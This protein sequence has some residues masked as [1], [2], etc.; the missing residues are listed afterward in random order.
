LAGALC[1]LAVRC[2]KAPGPLGGVAI[3]FTV[4]NQTV[5]FGK[6]LQGTV[7]SRSLVLTSAGSVDLTVDVVP[8]GPPF[9]S[10][11]NI[12]V[13]R[14][15]VA[16]L[17]LWFDAGT[18]V[19]DGTVTLSAHGKSVSVPLHG[20]GVQPLV[21]TAP[22][23]RVST[24]DLQ[25]ESCVVTVAADGT[26]CVPTSLCLDNGVCTAGVCTGSPRNCDDHDAC[27]TDTCA[28]S[29]G[30]VHSLVV[31]P[32]PTAACQV[33]T[34]SVTGGCGTAS[35]ADGTP[36]GS[37]DCTTA[38]VCVLGSCRGLPTPDGTPCLPPTP[39]QGQATCQSHVCVRPD[40]GDLTPV[41]SL[42]LDSAPGP[43]PDE[44]SG[45]LA[46]AGNLFWIACDAGCTLESFTSNGFNRFAQPL[47]DAGPRWL[48]GV[49]SA[50]VV[51]ASAQG[52]EVYDSQNGLLLWQFDGGALAAPL[53]APWAWPQT[54]PARAAVQADG[55]LFATFSWW[56]SGDAGMS[57]AGLPDAGLLPDVQSLA[58][59]GPDGG[60]QLAFLL[61][62]SGAQSRLALDASGHL[63][64]YDPDGPL[65]SVNSSDAGWVVVSLGSWPGAPSLATAAGRLL[66]G[67]A[68][69]LAVDGGLV[70]TLDAGSLAAPDSQFVLAADGQ[71]VGIYNA[72]L[73]PLLPPCTP[74][75]Q[76]VVLRVAD[77]GT[78]LDLWNVGLFPPGAPVQVREVALA[79]AG[80]VFTASDVQPDGGLETWVQLF[81]QGQ[82]VFRCRVP[83]PSNV[84]SALFDNGFFYLLNQRDGG[85]FL[86][87][88][89]LQGD[90]MDAYAWP[91]RNGVSGTR[92]EF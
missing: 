91:Q 31:C 46:F 43:V 83:P 24:F 26:S 1:L 13:P 5:D 38:H 75:Q 16:D 77:L 47:T 19:V 72:C 53:E 56:G 27:T 64:A 49:T 9:S 29:V 84:A 48:A 59:V 40:A 15:G 90:P 10:P 70:A 18:T 34:C 21:C 82:E 22:P 30:C 33:A 67:D 35:A 58:V 71:E 36:C 8:S 88:Y 25:S 85:W 74:D 4:P 3:G 92:R 66:V 37:V 17:S 62:G 6:A 80:T 89:D 81:A 76:T 44:A 63:F 28:E 60:V 42:G 12:L 55:T 52:P 68:W 45:L 51:L 86:E 41:F 20:E 14:G 61:R 54:G 23:C 2:H 69:L 50:G 73:P 57:D 78:G 87:A 11:A 65:A 7:V 32:P 79:Q 39:C